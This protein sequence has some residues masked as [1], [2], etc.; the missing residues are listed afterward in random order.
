MKPLGFVQRE[1][2]DLGSYISQER[3][4]HGQHDQEGVEGKDET[5]AAGDP[6]R[7]SKAVEGSQLLVGLLEV[8]PQDE[9]AKVQAMED[10]IEKDLSAG[11]MPLKAGRFGHFRAEKVTPM[12]KLWQSKNESAVE[13]NP[14]KYGHSR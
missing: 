13:E 5:S 7:E 9:D 4:A 1:P 3:P 14:A 12:S 8:P 10:D 11:K 2:P 6:N